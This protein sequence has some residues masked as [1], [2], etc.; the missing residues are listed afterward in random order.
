[1]QWSFRS[2]SRIYDDEQAGLPQEQ[3]VAELRRCASLPYD[4]ASL[5]RADA[6]PR[7]HFDPRVVEAMEAALAEGIVETGTFLAVPGSNEL[8][9]HCA[10]LQAAAFHPVTAPGEDL[11][12]WEAKGCGQE[13]RP[14]NDRGRCPVPFAAAWDGTNGGRA[15]GRSCWSV[16]GALCQN[17]KGALGSVGHPC[18]DCPFMDQVR[19]DTMLGSFVLLPRRGQPATA[20]RPAL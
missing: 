7:H 12:C 4:P 11:N 15:A 20:P 14:A 8:A 2:P 16:P 10:P 5:P 6:G 19:S 1:M 3:A 17:G 18:M 13:A 9:P